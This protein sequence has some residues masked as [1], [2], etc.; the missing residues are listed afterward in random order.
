MLNLD[1]RLATTTLGA[2][3]KTLRKIYLGYVRSSIDYTLSLQTIACKDC[4]FRFFMPFKCCLV[5]YSPSST[6]SLVTLSLHLILPNFLRNHI[7]I[8]Y[9]LASNAF[10]RVQLS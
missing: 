7:P 2:D 10:D 4:S 3:K 6:L 1:K 9:I 8:A 5:V